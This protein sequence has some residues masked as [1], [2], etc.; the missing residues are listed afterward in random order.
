MGGSGRFLGGTGGTIGLIVE[1]WSKM[2]FRGDTKPYFNG[3]R[4]NK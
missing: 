4:A 3:H 2:G 1:K